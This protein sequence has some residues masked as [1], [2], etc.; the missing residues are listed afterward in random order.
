MSQ[1]HPQT[2]PKLPRIIP[3]TQSKYFWG[4]VGFVWLLLCMGFTR[5]AKSFGYVVVSFT[6]VLQTL[7][8]ITHVSVEQ[9]QIAGICICVYIY[10]YVYM[11]V[12]LYEWQIALGPKAVCLFYCAAVYFQPV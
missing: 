6:W 10:I 4:V 8:L 5:T 7:K 2:P 3:R 11:Y 9:R 1:R 12:Y